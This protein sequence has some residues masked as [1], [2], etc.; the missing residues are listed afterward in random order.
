[1]FF[2]LT[3][4]LILINFRYNTKNL[5]E[6]PASKLLKANIKDLNKFVFITQIIIKKVKIYSKTISKIYI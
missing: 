1:M 4:I 6:I 2:L 5:L 3:L